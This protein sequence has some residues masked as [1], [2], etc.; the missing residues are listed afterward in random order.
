MDDKVEISELVLTSLPYLI[1]LFESCTN[2]PL[3]YSLLN[4]K[5]LIHSLSEIVY[6]LV[7]NHFK[8]TGGQKR[9]LQRHKKYLCILA[10]KNH[11]QRKREILKGQRGGSVVHSI[12]SITLPNLILTANGSTFSGE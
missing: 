6:N 1:V 12:L 4:K 5:K 10:E 11:F 3:F 7:H 8:L 9:K 2:K